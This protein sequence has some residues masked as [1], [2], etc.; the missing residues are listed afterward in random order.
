M[1]T[2]L[3]SRGAKGAR[4]A[5]EPPEKT[6]AGHCSAGA[7]AAVSHSSPNTVELTRNQVSERSAP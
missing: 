6:A 1:D 4:R 7:L 5:T 2:S 3:F